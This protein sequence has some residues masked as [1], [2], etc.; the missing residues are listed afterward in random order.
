MYAIIQQGGHQYKVEPGK[1]LEFYNLPQKEG[2]KLILKEILLLVDKTNVL[3]GQP[4]VPNATVTLKILKHL[5]GEKIRVARFKAKSRYTK[6]KG[7]RQ[8]LVKVHVE[9]IGS[10]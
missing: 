2:E 10:R 6:V 1:D 7:S 9:S 5:K 8:S 4:F 3:V